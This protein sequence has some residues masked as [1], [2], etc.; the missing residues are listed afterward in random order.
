MP[1]VTDA[2]L[3]ARRQH[4]ID[5]ARAQF[6]R[7]GFHAT[8]MQDLLS[9]T[10]L[11]A[12]AFYR[13]FDSKTAIITAIARESMVDVIAALTAAADEGGESMGGAVARAIEIVAAKENADDFAALAVQAWGEALRDPG[14][15]AL[16]NETL[17]PS[18]DALVK[19]VRRKQREGKLPVSVKADGLMSVFFS[20]LPGYL[21]QRA[22]IGPQAVAGVPGAIRALF[23]GT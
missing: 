20:L 12:G 11:S 3:A 10:G 5:S 19:V 21:V 15:N 4:I 22:V 1:K 16:L 18:R 9:A 13:Y 14:F 6:A 8:S 23:A 17:A 7:N 2:Y